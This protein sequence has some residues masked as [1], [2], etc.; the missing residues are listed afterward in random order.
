MANADKKSDS[1][2]VYTA[3]EILNRAVTAVKQ[4]KDT[5]MA[6]FDI[7][8]KNLINSTSE[9]RVDLAIRDIEQLVEER[10]RD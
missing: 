1:D 9:N 3:H 7:V 4:N 5:D 10:V 6:L 8:E 2:A